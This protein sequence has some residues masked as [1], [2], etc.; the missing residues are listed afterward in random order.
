MISMLKRLP[1]AAILLVAALAVPTAPALSQDEVAPEHL[2]WRANTS[3]S[4]TR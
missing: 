3:T 1:L 2:P 4:P